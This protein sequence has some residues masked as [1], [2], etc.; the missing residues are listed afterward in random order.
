MG[1][2]AVPPTARS[3][4]VPHVYLGYRA[5]GPDGAARIRLDDG[6]GATTA[7]DAQVLAVVEGFWQV[8]DGQLA[9]KRS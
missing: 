6:Q 1:S 3:S 5:V 8:L 2:C 7:D 4:V 9:D